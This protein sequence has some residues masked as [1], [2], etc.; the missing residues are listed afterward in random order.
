ML[1]EEEDRGGGAVNHDYTSSMGYF[2]DIW[3]PKS[4][5]NLEHN[6]QLILLFA[7]ILVAH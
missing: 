4:I 3:Q 7:H 5:Q 2:Q 1:P 6:K